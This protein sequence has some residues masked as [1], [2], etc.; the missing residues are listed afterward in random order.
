MKDTIAT[1]IEFRIYP[2]GQTMSYYFDNYTGVKDP[3][4]ILLFKVPLVNFRRDN[5]SGACFADIDEKIFLQRLKDTWVKPD[6]FCGVINDF[7]KHF[8][9]AR[10]NLFE[11]ID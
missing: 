5:E 8:I 1:S 2:G 9:P 3:R 10:I 6:C 11:S 4:A 7:G